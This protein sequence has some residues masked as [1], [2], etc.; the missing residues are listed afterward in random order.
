MIATNHVVDDL[1]SWIIGRLPEGGTPNIHY[2]E[3]AWT[4]AIDSYEMFESSTL[5]MRVGQNAYLK[6]IAA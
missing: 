3:T 2:V 5:A 4:A 6:A 1:T